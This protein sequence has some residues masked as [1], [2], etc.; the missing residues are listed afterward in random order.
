MVSLG[1]HP[2]SGSQLEP[3]PDAVRPDDRSRPDSVDSRQDP[4]PDSAPNAVQERAQDSVREKVLQTAAR[5]AEEEAA[6]KP[7]R[8]T[9]V[10]DGALLGGVCTGLAKHLGWPVMVLRIGFVAL[11]LTQ[12]VGVIA[13]AA[14]WLLMPPES[15][16]STPGLDA[17]SR[18]GLRQQP[19]RLF[20]RRGDWGRCW[21]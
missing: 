20:R 8:A 3:G 5:K 18:Q 1:A 10:T 15:K 13:Y 2:R 9:R 7:R 4:S 17:H 12:F 14:L 19:Q 21:P 6:P 11:A 16:T